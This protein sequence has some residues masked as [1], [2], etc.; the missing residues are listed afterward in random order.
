MPYLKDEF[1]EEIDTLA[2]EANSL[3]GY[4]ESVKDDGDWAGAINYVNCKI[5]LSRLHRERGRWGRYWRY[6]LWVGT[7]VC[8]ILEVYRRLVAPYED[9]AIDRNGDVVA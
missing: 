8:C 7:M 5:L 1:R 3:Y 4:L 9:K 2:G 6:A